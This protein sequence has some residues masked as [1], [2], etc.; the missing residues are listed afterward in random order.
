MAQLHNCGKVGRGTRCHALLNNGKQCPYEAAMSVH[1]FG[2]SEIYS[3]REHNTSWV[4]VPFCK[5]HL[6]PK[7]T[8]HVEPQ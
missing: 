8:P 1:Y 2:D 6:Q 5:K 7:D 4:L 3:E